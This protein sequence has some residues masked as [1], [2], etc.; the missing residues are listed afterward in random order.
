MAVA[1]H[2]RGHGV[3]GSPKC[4]GRRHRQMKVFVRLRIAEVQGAST[5]WVG[6]RLR[7]GRITPPLERRIRSMLISVIGY[8]NNRFLVRRPIP[9]PPPP[10]LCCLCL[11]AGPPL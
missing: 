3:T 4:Q 11:E 9:H 1:G 2:A 10:L 8:T 6:S 5:N 7:Y